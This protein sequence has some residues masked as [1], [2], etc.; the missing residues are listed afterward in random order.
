MLN[1]S[2]LAMALENKEITNIELPIF[3]L[4]GKNMSKNVF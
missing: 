2:T 3:Y 4:E 1:L